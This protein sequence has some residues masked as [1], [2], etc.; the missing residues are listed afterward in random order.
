MSDLHI[1]DSKSLYGSVEVSQCYL[2]MMLDDGE[3]RLLGG[4]RVGSLGGG[5]VW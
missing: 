2:H 3:E 5:G 1:A 4:S